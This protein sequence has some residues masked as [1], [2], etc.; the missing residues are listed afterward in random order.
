MPKVNL[1]VAADLTAVALLASIPLVMV[2]SPV[3][4]HNTLAEFIGF[5]K[6]NPG[7][8]TYGSAGRGDSTHLA[9]ERL[10][11]AAKF[12]GLYVPFRGALEVLSEIIA[13][14][15]DFYMAPTAAALPA[16]GGG[17]LRALAV[18]SARRAAALP[19]VPTTLESGLAN[20]DYE[21]WVGAFVNRATRSE[22][23]TALHRELSK[24]LTSSSVQERFK[25]LGAE[26]VLRTPREFADQVRSE[27]RLNADLAKEAGLGN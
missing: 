7:A 16:I 8:V 11:L 13:G 9:A 17:Q 5:A 18:A 6:S 12:Q 15:L 21:F 2:V 22:V 20:S 4:G 14:R 3:G 27:I 23:V 25:A 24:A 1:H 10:R 26:V 19:D